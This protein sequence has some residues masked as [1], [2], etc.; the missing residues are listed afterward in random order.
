MIR[1]DKMHVYHPQAA[2]LDV[3]KMQVTAS[4][5]RRAEGED[6]ETE[7]RQFSALPSGLCALVLWLIQCGVTA[8]ALEATGIF[9]E[10]IYDRLVDAGL[11]VLVTHAQHV[12][13]IKGRKTDRSDSEWLARICQFQLARSSLVLSKEMR[14]LRQLSRYRRRLVGLRSQAR[15][16]IHKIL[17][18]NGLRLG[19]IL[20]DVFGVNGRRLLEG[21][22]A[23]T[24]REE[25]VNTLSYH[26][27]HHLKL[28]GD[29]I[30]IECDEHSRWMLKDL[31]HRQH[32]ELEQQIAALDE[33]LN[34]ALTD[35]QEQLYWLQT[36]PG[37]N[38][39]SAQAIIIEIGGDISKFDS[40][41]HFAAW[42]GLCPGNNESA[43]KR[44]HGHIRHGNAALRATLVECA[45]GAVRTKDCHFYGYHRR[46]KALA[47]LQTSF[48]RD[49]T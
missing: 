28:L 43:G 9:W 44:R 38:L 46:L 20:S 15:V 48:D 17:D 13:Q 27:R 31:L 10:R 4:V 2:G 26:V 39:I 5:R 29:A 22:I 36:I 45:H 32:D 1:K 14:D 35:Y 24:P 8:A 37:V 25:L 41:R 40:A 18:R 19:G 23:G 7:T 11:Q 30:S 6:F 3:H 47:W 33:R 16:R 34:I 21:L 49:R 12:K 42:V